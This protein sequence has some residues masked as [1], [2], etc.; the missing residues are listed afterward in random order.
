MR[1]ALSLIL[2]P[3][4]LL[5]GAGQE[6]LVPDWLRE[7]SSA[8]GGIAESWGVGT[9][10]N[11]DVYWTASADSMGQGLDIFCYKYDSDGNPLWPA[12]LFFGGL[13]TQHAFVCN[14]QGPALYIG[15]RYCPLTGFSCD[16]LLLKADKSTGALLW[17]QTLDFGNNGYDE[18]DGLE[19]R[20]DGIYGGGWAQALQ[21]GPYQ[22]DIGLWKLD[23]EGNTEWTSHFGKTGTA[24][25]Q[26]GHFV[27]DDDF[28]YV[29]GVWGATGIANAYNGHSFLGK[30]SK[31]SGSFVD[32]TLFGYPSPNFLDAENALGMTTDGEFLYITGY[33]TPVSS[34][35]WQV[36][37]AKFDKD[38]NQVWFEDWGGSGTD[39]ARGIAVKDGK[40]FVAGVTQSPEYTP[41][42]N[43]EALLLVYDTGGNLLHYHT[44]GDT[45]DNGFRDIAIS[46]NEI[47]LSGTSGYQLFSG[48]GGDIGF[49]LKTNYDALLNAPSLSPIEDGQ[50]RVFPNPL[51]TSAIIQADFD[52]EGYVF[53]V[54]DLFGI[55]VY[56]SELLAG[57]EAKFDRGNLVSGMYLFSLEGRQKRLSGKL[58]I[59]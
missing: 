17:D 57:T 1:K 56:H 4:A 25:H 28:I 47:Y 43:S 52:L 7:K 10:N 41:G 22:L 27:V 29:A 8:V 3:A 13:G 49:L 38:L 24:E 44:W 55:Q 30:F 5:S 33:T 11:G 45:L 21:T 19:V 39:N 12:P 14:A 51:S 34:D 53:S 48:G 15:G 59:E 35:N 40:I 50:V 36:F 42:D 6:V 37:V 2:L 9:D 32:S 18:V 16:M 20:D 54:F 23:P 46:G 58:V 26:D 31:D